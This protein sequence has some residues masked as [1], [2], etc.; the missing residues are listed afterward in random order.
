[1]TALASG[2]AEAGGPEQQ[3]NVNLQALESRLKK[4]LEDEAAA[5]K[6]R[7]ARLEAMETA[8]V[9]LGQALDAQAEAMIKQEGPLTA[10]L[11]VDVAK[12]AEA[13]LT[14]STLFK[15]ARIALGLIL[16]AF[17]GS[18]F[19]FGIEIKSVQSSADA[20]ILRFQGLENF[21]ASRAG[22]IDTLAK[23]VTNHLA[24]LTDSA[25]SNTH[26][27]VDSLRV[28][29]RLGHDSLGR[30]LAAIAARRDTSLIL[31]HD[32]SA[33]ALDILGKLTRSAHDSLHIALTTIA[34]MR[35]T[36]LRARLS[37][38]DSMVV[39]IDVR[40]P[41]RVTVLEGLAV[42]LALAAFLVAVRPRWFKILGTA[43]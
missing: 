36:A 15:N 24:I 34:A 26:R 33:A 17:G 7:Q 40:R 22:N 6:A 27:L 29:K 8:G 38:R 5:A 11:V 3:G 39:T 42:G 35:D 32:S 4:A 16:V 18:L 14:S 28:F 41:T 9:K 2:G 10:L 31:L 30:A 37:G 25:D 20:A 19:Y 1:M 13:T 43:A 21:L 12:R 23:Q